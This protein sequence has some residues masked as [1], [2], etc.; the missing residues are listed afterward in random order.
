VAEDRKQIVVL[1]G[2]KGTRLTSAGIQTP[3]LLLKVNQ[4]SLVEI[5]VHEAISEG[6]TDILWCIGHGHEEVNPKIQEQVVLNRSI[7]QKIFIENEQ[8]GTLGALIQARNHLQ[9]DFCIILGDLLLKRTNLGGLFSGFKQLE[10]EA[11]LLVKY[12]DHPADSDL[13]EINK[14][15]NVEKL[16]RYPHQIVPKLPIG[17][18]GVLFLRKELIPENYHLEN[19]DVFKHLIPDLLTRGV[20]IK[21]TFHQGVIRDIGTPK[22]LNEATKVFVENEGMSEL[23]GIFFDRDG[24]LNVENGHIR[25]KSQ[26]VALPETKNILELAIEK[27]DKVGIVTNQPVISRGEATIEDVQEINIHLINQAGIFDTREVIFKV[28]PHHPDSGF[29]GEVIELKVI[30]ECRKPAPGLLLSI[31][32]ENRLRSNNALYIGNSV[33]DIQAAES[34]SMKWIHLVENENNQCN[35]HPS[36]KSGRCMSAKNLV[37]FLKKVEIS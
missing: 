16:L 8:R 25:S 23:R 19:A 31:L 34:A 37:S 17:N 7:S 15:L 27:F 14:D 6:F 5:I 20:T 32:N 1:A 36:L 29:A 28:C 10:E 4:M 35:L 18:A 9:E 24:T 26:V 11:R 30:C 21:T 12:T 33:T 13:V 22:R 2:G 3:K